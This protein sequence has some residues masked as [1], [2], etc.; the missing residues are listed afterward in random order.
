[1]NTGLD[2]VTPA[3]D[4]AAPR[5]PDVSSEHARGP[6]KTDLGTISIADGVVTKIAARAATEVP[7]AGAA[8]P[9][10]L[11]KSLTGV[12]ALG[13]RQSDLSG[14]P[15]TTVRVDGHVALIDI[16]LSV[17]WPAPIAETTE[18]VRDRV[19]TRIRDLTG[20]QVSEVTITVTDLVT[21]IAPT[22]RVR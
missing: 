12:G 10:V 2:K 21:R 11:G 7:D 6:G 20:L 9:R 22:A 5:S 1:M 19:R 15:K 16:S 13:I 14:L 17:R 8:A 4:A 3:R 18:R